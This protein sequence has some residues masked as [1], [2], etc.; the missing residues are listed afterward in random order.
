M[1]MRQPFR[2]LC[3]GLCS[4]AGRALPLL[5]V[6]SLPLLAQEPEIISV[7]EVQGAKKLAAETVVFKSGLKVGDDLRNVNLSSV[8]ERLWASGSYEDIRFLVED[9]KGGGGKKLIIRVAER[10]IIKDVDYRGGT[11]IG[12]SSLKEKIKDKKLNI[13]ENSVYDPEAARKVKSLIVEQCADKGFRNPV[14][15]VNLEPMSGG[16]ARLVFDIKEGGKVRI[17]DVKFRGNKVL[18]DSDLAGAMAK[19]RKHWMFSWITSH[20]L[21]V[22]K[23]MEDDLQN[24]KNTYWKKGYKDVFVGQP[25]IEVEDFTTASQKSKNIKRIKEGKSP[26]YDLRATL[27]IPILEGDQFFEGKLFIDGNKKAFSGK[28]GER[29]LRYKIAEAKRDNRS[30]LAKTLDIKPNVEDLPANKHVP[31]DLDAMNK[32]VENIGEIYR[33]E[34]YAQFH[35]EKKLE[36]R[37]ENG[38]KKVDTTLKLNEGE[39]FRIR[40]ISFEGNTKTKDKVLRRALRIKEGDPFSMD[41]FRDSFIGLGQLGFFDVKNQNPDVIP[42]PEKPV[43]DIVIKGEEAGVNEIQF[44]SSYGQ[45]QGFGL[46]ATFSTKNLGGNGETLG[47]SFNTSKY[48]KTFAVNFLEPYV[49]DTPYSFSSSLSTSTE[50]SSDDSRI[51]NIYRT[52]RYYQTLGLGTGVRLSVLLPNSQAWWANWTSYN[53]SYNFQRNRIEGGNNFFFR[54]DRT[55]LTSSVSQSLVYSTI[56]HPFKATSG[57]KFGVNLDYGGWQF[58]TD[59]PYYRYGVE[60]SKVGNI[61]DRHIF[62]ANFN[63]GYLGNLSK[64]ELP[65]WLMFRPGGENTIRGYRHE[66]VGSVRLDP[67]G[68][69]GFVGGNR[70]FIANFE[71]RLKI[72]DQFRAVLFLDAGNAWMPGEKMFNRNLVT[73]KYNGVEPVQYRNPA[74]VRSTGLELQF[75]LPISPAPLRLIFARKL[76]LYPFDR[77][78]KNEF[79]FSFGT[80]F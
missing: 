61:A 13:A 32:G 12:L 17:Y 28:R 27:V 51:G 76:D 63:Y 57:F 59:K 45:Y 43:V 78:G 5:L 66:S 16:L 31:Y 19:T 4:G 22:E 73:F 48:Q 49:F 10:P 41:I 77:E 2:S 71:Y 39:A 1:Q 55:H 69:P 35:A 20:D 68:N 42:D 58:G 44:T 8:L 72:A 26:K 54:D 67:F 53:L 15:D 11:E 14:V 23:N 60:L 47:F 30:F 75:F 37:E 9:A 79:Q 56:N 34:S 70:Q 6:A 25:L 80:T 24:I 46:G 52:K 3:A 36:V 40:R 62:A 7:I 50:K 64:E 33:N 65:S 74:M 18:S 21:L 38:V 29:F